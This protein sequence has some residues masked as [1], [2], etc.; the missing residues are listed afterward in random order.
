MGGGSVYIYI[1]HN[2][3]DPV[4]STCD[5]LK[6][7]IHGGSNSTSGSNGM[8]VLVPGF[9]GG[10][11]WLPIW[12]TL[13]DPRSASPTDHVILRSSRASRKFWVPPAARVHK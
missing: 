7:S 6:K 11:M 4:V 9:F 2:Q 1:Y 8:G 12:G 3:W 10:N 13:T 5:L